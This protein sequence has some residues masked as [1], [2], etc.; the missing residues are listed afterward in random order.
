[1]KNEQIKEKAVKII[2]G[3]RTGV[4]STVE[5]NKPHSRYMTF[6]NDDLTL[7]TPTQMDTEKIEE[8]KNN[9]SVSVLLGYEQNGQSDAY[10][11]ITGTTSID[12][13][14]ELKNKY[15]DESFQQWFDGP[16]DP[17]Y[18]LLQIQP[19]IVRILNN[20]GGPSQE[21]ILGQ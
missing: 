15:W 8:I 5:N 2:S 13:S 16:Q 6:Y 12:Q 18:G 9:P 1:M 20:E 17:N 3:H 21:L 7:Y 4:L 10:V 11:Q 19:D 14:Q